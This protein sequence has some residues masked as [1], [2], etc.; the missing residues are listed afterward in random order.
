MIGVKFSPLAA[1]TR[2]AMHDLAGASP[3]PPWRRSGRDLM[4]QMSNPPSGVVRSAW[5]GVGRLC[6]HRGPARMHA[7]YVAPLASLARV[8]LTTC[9]GLGHNADQVAL[10]LEVALR[11]EMPYG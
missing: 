7:V 5:S 8:G 2:T 3:N 6:R 1:R 9:G 10:Q 11:L 4:H